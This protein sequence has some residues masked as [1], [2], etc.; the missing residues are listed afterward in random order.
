MHVR[1]CERLVFGDGGWGRLAKELGTWREAI[2][3]IE[4]MMKEQTLLT[5]TST[6]QRW[7][8]S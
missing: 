5:P 8:A 3:G 6:V 4:V 2:G 7:L 1:R